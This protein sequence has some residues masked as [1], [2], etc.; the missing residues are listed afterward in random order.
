MDFVSGVK[1]A[2]SLLP[3]ITEAVQAVENAVP[4]AGAGTAKL[5]AVKSILQDVYTVSTD[6]STS[7]FNDIWPRLEGMIGVVVKLFNDTGIFK[8]SAQ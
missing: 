8:K 7:N 2:L 4:Q 5:E 3:A 1:I 6:V